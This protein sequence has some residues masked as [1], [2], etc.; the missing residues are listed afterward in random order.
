[1]T[2][3]RGCARIPPGRN[4]RHGAG[5]VNQAADGPIPFPCSLN[6]PANE[7]ATNA[8]HEHNPAHNDHTLPGPEPAV[9]EL[10]AA[11]PAWFA[12]LTLPEQ[13]LLI[14]LLGLGMLWLVS[15]LPA[16]AMRHWCERR[17]IGRAIRRLG[18]RSRRNA[19]LPDGLGGETRIDFLVLAGDAILVIG[20]KRYDG[21]IFGSTRTDEWIQTLHSRSYKFPNPDARLAQQVAAVRALVPKA[22][23]RG[24]HLFTDSA[25]FP[26]DKPP[27]VLQVGDVLG[28][29]I[30]PPRIKDIP[31]D[32][33]AAWTQVL[34]TA[35]R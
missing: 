15:Q 29:D 20:V 17:R 31:G 8:T 3:R 5:A 4:R 24:L 21:M 30:R 2:T 33:R 9:Q 32:L 13:I 16:T 34:Q 22:A 27:N 1:M 25:V 14:G 11:I 28:S 19:T 26:R 7:P 23:V 6:A 12:R 10:T 18:A 35:R